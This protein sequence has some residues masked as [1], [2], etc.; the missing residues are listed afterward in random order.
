MKNILKST[1][2]VLVAV[3]MLCALFTACDSTKTEKA[4]VTVEI[5]DD[6]G[7]IFLKVVDMEIADGTTAEEAVAALCTLR[8]ATF[9]KDINGDY[10]SFTFDGKTV[11]AKQEN[12]SN[13]NVKMFSVAWKLND[14]AMSSTEDGATNVKMSEKALVNG[15]KVTVY[16]AV[17]E[18]TPAATF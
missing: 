5:Y 11:A 10:D 15:D 3:L 4:K 17:S 12:L 18:V 6:A 7:V 8:E 2:S 14:A 13:G 9:T 1:L 16:F